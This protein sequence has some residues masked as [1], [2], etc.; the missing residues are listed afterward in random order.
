MT[1]KWIVLPVILSSGGV[2]VW[3]L[4]ADATWEFQVYHFFFCSNLKQTAK[5]T[6]SLKQN[7][8]LHARVSITT[9]K[10]FFLIT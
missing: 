3:N 5:L 1:P 4:R 8:L 6:S 2:Q 7:Y 9:Y 10:H